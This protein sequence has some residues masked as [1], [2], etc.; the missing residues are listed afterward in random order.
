MDG[1]IKGGMEAEADTRW[2]EER[3]GHFAHIEMSSSSSTPP[4]SSWL[5]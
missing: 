4:T 1:W 2:L 5:A 3:K